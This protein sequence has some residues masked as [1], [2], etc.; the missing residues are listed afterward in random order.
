MAINA[1]ISVKGNLDLP[2]VDG[3]ITVT[4]NTDFTFVL[5][6]SS[7]ALQEREGIIEFVD[8]DQL[9]LADTLEET[10][11]LDQTISGL[12]VNLNIEIDKD[13]LLSIIIDKANGDF[14]KLQGEAQLTG[15][16]DPSGKTTLVG[17]Y[18]VNEGA[19]EMSVS[20]LKRRFEI[21]EGSTITWTGEPMEA[22][23][24][25]T[26]VYKTKAAPLDLVQQQVGGDENI[27]LYKQRIP[28]NTLLKMTGELLKPII[29]FDIEV[30]GNNPGVSSDVISMVDSK[31]SQLRTEQS[32]MNKQVFALLL[33]NRFIGENPFESSTGLSAESVARQSVSRMLSEQLNNLAA[34]LIEGVELNFDLESSD[35]YSTGTRENRTDLNIGV[36]KSLLNDR[37]KVSVGSNFGLEGTER[38]NEEMTNIAGDV[39]IEYLLSRDGRYTLKAYRKNEYQL[40]LQGQII[41]TGVGFVI[42]LDY[43][44][45]KEIWQR[46]R[47]NR[48]FRRTQRNVQ[49]EQTTTTTK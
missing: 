5:P 10:E 31:L 11:T 29:S 22:D 21:Q 7:P 49:N 43:N 34:D 1:N 36:S 40:A 15:G 18:E 28:F 12:D 6:Q 42:T 19:Y 17:R 48:E 14:I 46:R 41:E 35:D 44:E 4:D 30:D 13:A 3:T 26:A 39:Q 32:E 23:V 20:L 8:Q 9:A 47:R 37:L 2:K 38:Q 16:I 24:D 33:L 27:N 45:F 25:I